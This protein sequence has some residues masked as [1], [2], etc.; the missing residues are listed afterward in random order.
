M[1]SSGKGLGIIA[2]LFA[3]GALGLGV[4]QIILPP[5]SPPDIPEAP[6]IYV[7]TNYEIV[8]LY[9]DVIELIP[10]LNVTYNVNA[11]DSILLEFSCEIHIDCSGGSQS[12][13]F[14][15]EIN[16][17]PP[18]PYTSMTVIGDGSGLFFHSSIIMRA[19]IQSNTADTHVVEVLTWTHDT[20]SS[21]IR[22][23]VLSATVY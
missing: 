7:G 5:A 4:Y 20:S 18:S 17:S 8:T 21:Y 13:D 2:L 14:Y 23:C 1:G 10:N 11:G 6:Q 16:G 19:N 12:I 15:F 3:M 9:L 22:E